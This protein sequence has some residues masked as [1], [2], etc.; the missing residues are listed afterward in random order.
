MKRMIEKFTRG[1]KRREEQEKETKRSLDKVEIDMKTRNLMQHGQS[2][3]EEERRS[4]IEKIW[5]EFRYEEKVMLMEIILYD[6]WNMLPFDNRSELEEKL[7][8]IRDLIRDCLNPEEKAIL[9]VRYGIGAFY[10]IRTAGENREQNERSLRVLTE[11][12]H[13][14]LYQRFSLS[15]NILYDS[16]AVEL[17]NIYQSVEE[18][19]RF[20]AGRQFVSGG[21]SI[22]VCKFD[23]KE[24]T[25]MCRRAIGKINRYMEAIRAGRFEQAD[26]YC[27]MIFESEAVEEIS[28]SWEVMTS[29]IFPMISSLYPAEVSKNIVE[30]LHQANRPVSFSSKE[31]M[32]AFVLQGNQILCQSIENYQTEKNDSMIG[33]LQEYIKE[34][35]G[36]PE[37]NVAFLAEQFGITPNYLSSRYR[38]QTGIKLTEYIQQIRLAHAEELL[39]QT[40]QKVQDIARQC[41][42]E[43]NVGYFQQSFR[44]KQGMSPSE[45]RKFCNTEK[46]TKC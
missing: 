4:M 25:D 43:Y 44:K 37:I 14:M 7:H 20:L 5:P 46:T 15:A 34:H 9:E 22:D 19:T 42:Y 18:I 17:G 13:K 41:G 16:E 28:F 12:I 33:R 8:E 31:E 11:W 29:S 21:S 10:V 26:E 38:R 6:I 39:R 24:Y 32:L 1:R 23:S 40:N 45:Y 35:Y 30:Y 36:N 27:R 2:F 3:S